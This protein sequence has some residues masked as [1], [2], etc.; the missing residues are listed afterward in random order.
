[1]KRRALMVTV[2]VVVGML[3]VSATASAVKPEKPDKP[4]SPAPGVTCAEWGPGWNLG[5]WNGS[6]YVVGVPGC[7]DI[8]EQHRGVTEWMVSWDLVPTKSMKGVLLRF[9][10][11]EAELGRLVL[12]DQYVATTETGSVMM[13][14]SQ[15]PLTVIGFK[16]VAMPHNADRYDPG[17][18]ITVT[19]DS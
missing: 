19:P 12:S 4:E 8:L 3:A 14:T 10:A 5:E 1:M 11:F 15:D 6:A 13:S 9:E 16:F 7:I 18:T 2:L 17:S